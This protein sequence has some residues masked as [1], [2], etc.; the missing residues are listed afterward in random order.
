MISG[1]AYRQH[2]IV[3]RTARTRHGQ[4]IFDEAIFRHHFRAALMPYKHQLEKRS[5]A[6]IT[7]R[8]AVLNHHRE[9]AFL[10]LHGFQQGLLYPRKQGFYAAVGLQARAQY[11]RVGKVPHHLVHTFSGSPHGGCA[12]QKIIGTGHLVHHQ[13]IG[14]LNKNEWRDAVVLTK[15]FNVGIG[16]L[17]NV[18]LHHFRLQ[19]QNRRALKIA[20]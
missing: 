16:L 14:G 7:G 19:L 8:V 4:D 2:H 3:R 20:G 15:G 1:I 5:T 17:G 9:W 6:A 12:H 13:L 11:H 10:V 18:L